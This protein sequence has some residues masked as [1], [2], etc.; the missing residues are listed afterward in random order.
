MSEAIKVSAA[1]SRGDGKE[2]QNR[3]RPE[4]RPA[5]SFPDQSERSVE[6]VAIVEVLQQAFHLR[7]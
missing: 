6:V 2:H 3:E 1:V 4:E 5:H 7:R